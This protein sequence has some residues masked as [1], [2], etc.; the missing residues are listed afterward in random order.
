MKA[1]TTFT[2]VSSPR[3]IFTVL[4]ADTYLGAH[5]VKHLRENDRM[6]CCVAQNEDFDCGIEP[7]CINELNKVSHGVQ[8][9]ETQW[10]VV[11]IDPGI[12]F[13]KYTSKIKKLCDN[14]VAKEFTGNICFFSSA[15]ICQSGPEPIS[16][17]TLVFPRTEQDLALATG[18]NLLAV[19]SCSPH[20]YASPHIMRIGVPYGNETGITETIGFV[21]E[22]IKAAERNYN[23]TI[24]KPS[25][26]MRTLTHISDICESA[27]QLMCLEFC[28][29]LVNIPGEMKTIADVAGLVAQKFG[30]EFEEKGL[31]SHDEQDYYAGD[32]HLSAEYFNNTVKYDRKY[33]FEQ[34]LNEKYFGKYSLAHAD[35]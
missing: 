24:K 17:E 19:L 21:N 10:L 12:G 35:N 34:W 32:Q 2:T 1:E 5:M 31:S 18:E 8:V 23:F 30:V 28:P 13:E 27:L 33:I 29:P 3:A 26:A 15:T 22:I 25:G 20:G 4:G 7:L 6:V 14:L 11:C 16:E 9:V